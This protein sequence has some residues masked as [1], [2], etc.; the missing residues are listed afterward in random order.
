RI[1]MSVNQL[2]VDQDCPAWV[3]AHAD[4]P[5]PAGL[6]LRRAGDHR[7]VASPAAADRP[8]LGPPFVAVLVGNAI[9][10]VL[11]GLGEQTVESNVAGAL[12]ASAPLWTVAIAFLA[13]NRSSGL[14]SAR[15]WVGR[16]VP[17]H[18]SDLLPLATTS[19]FRW[20]GLACLGAAVSDGISY[21]Y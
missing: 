17:R 18:R 2:P 16:R 10:C 12:N 15:G 19:V 8:R 4:H 1:P 5:C 11:F 21:L 6:G 20:S 14:A 13:G 9:P 7:P 3:L